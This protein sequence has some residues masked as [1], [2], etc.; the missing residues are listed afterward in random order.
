MG[1]RSWNAFSNNI[2]RTIIDDNLAALTAKIYKV[3]G[4]NDFVSLA[5]KKK[6]T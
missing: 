6:N 2:N 3:Y 5:G 4:K 1:W